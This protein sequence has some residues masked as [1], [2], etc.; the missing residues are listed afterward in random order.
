MREVF[1]D[2]DVTIVE[3]YKGLLDD[4]GIA[5]FVRNPAMA[6]ADVPPTLCVMNEADRPRALEVLK[7]N[8]K[9][10]APRP[11]WTCRCGGV[12]PGTFATCGMCGASFVW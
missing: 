2:T 4:A 6:A 8:T 9:L 10:P 7:A 12:N 1:A 3:F 5:C 11:M